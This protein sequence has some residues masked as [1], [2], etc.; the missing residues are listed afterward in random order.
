MEYNDKPD[1]REEFNEIETEIRNK[2][3][4][5][6]NE[7]T[8]YFDEIQDLKDVVKVKN[9]TSKMFGLLQ[10][11]PKKISLEEESVFRYN[12]QNLA[13]AVWDLRGGNIQ[14]FVAPSDTDVEA[15]EGINKTTNISQS[16]EVS[17]FIGQDIL[18]NLINN[19]TKLISI[20]INRKMFNHSSDDI[21]T[22]NVYVDAY[23]SNVKVS[24]TPFA[25]TATFKRPLDV[26]GNA[27]CV[28]W[29][30]Q[31]KAGFGNWSSE[32][33]LSETDEKGNIVC[34]CN[35]MTTFAVLFG[36][37]VPEEIIKTVSEISKIGCSLSAFCLFVTI[38]IYFLNLDNHTNLNKL[39]IHTAFPALGVMISLLVGFSSFPGDHFCIV[40][41]F[42]LHYFILVTFSWFLAK[43]LLLHLC[44]VRGRL[45]PKIFD[46]FYIWS[47]RICWGVTAIFPIINIVLYQ[48][49]YTISS[50]C[51][52]IHEAFYYTFILPFTVL[53]LFN[54]LIT[55]YTVIYVTKFLQ[56]E[57]LTDDLAKD[58]KYHLKLIIFT[59]LLTV[60]SW[61]PGVISGFIDSGV[62]DYIFC[63][64]APTQGLFILVTHMLADSHIRIRFYNFYL[65]ITSKTLSP[66]TQQEL[67]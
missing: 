36:S 44:L 13:V 4:V 52:I 16:Y 22:S 26:E 24:G 5:T 48:F 63:I 18:N 39:I 53:I 46:S 57:T 37:N 27:T 67:M 62:L 23:L 8:E 12:K 7:T 42:F 59:F 56:K 1:P 6:V 25:V 41:S 31:L 43:C 30:Y 28:F 38:V 19:D 34:I 58:L 2:K 51:W 50:T 40:F 3:S 66:S 61:I 45:L 29:D 54:T 65:S 49:T 32:G 21:T 55:S 9:G 15:I 11:L 17:L 64:L 35:H 33:C 14:G 47:I 20:A 60:A 10:E